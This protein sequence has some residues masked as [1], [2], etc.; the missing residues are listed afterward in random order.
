MSRLKI[1]ISLVAILI[2]LALAVFLVRRLPSPTWAD[3][4][5]SGQGSEVIAMALAPDG[6]TLAF[7]LKRRP[8]IRTW[9]ISR[10]RQKQVL[11]APGP[12]ADLVF[13]ASGRLVASDS[14]CPAHV[15][16][17][18]AQ[19]RLTSI[20]PSVA[21]P[22][23]D[24]LYCPESQ[25]FVVAQDKRDH[26][27]SLISIMDATDGSTRFSTESVGG[28]TTSIGAAPGARIIALGTTSPPS[29]SATALTTLMHVIN[30]E[31]MHILS[32]FCISGVPD[33]CALSPDG[34]LLA[35]WSRNESMTI[36]IWRTDTGALGKRL[37]V[38]IK[39]SLSD[40]RFSPDGQMLAAGAGS[41]TSSMVPLVRRFDYVYGEVRLWDSANAREL[42]VFN[43]KSPVTRIAFSSNGRCL[44]A[45]SEDGTLKVWTIDRYL[46]R[47]L[48]KD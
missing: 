40:V 48:A 9:D 15:R 36:E 2:S 34:H 6:S 26:K 41:R 13:T 45:G 31:D 25:R 20:L 27:A 22:C 35:T 10:G 12:I 46:N 33:S 28:V 38:P 23:V 11:T 18:D 1:P 43:E 47:G 44:A 7:S 24:S 29:S 5:I 19:G 17:W 32:T 3:I 37:H 8:D 21:G 14:N 16:I 30:V 42:G 39:A 4:T